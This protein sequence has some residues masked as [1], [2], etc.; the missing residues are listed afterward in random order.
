VGRF[1]ILILNKV[2][3]KA[4]IPDEFMGILFKVRFDLQH[5]IRPDR[6]LFTG[7]ATSRHRCSRADFFV[8]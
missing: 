4:P 1:R 7:R 8:D 3:N 5:S 6:F 2:V